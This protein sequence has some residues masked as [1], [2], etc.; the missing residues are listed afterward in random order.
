LNLAFSG[1]VGHGSFND[2]GVT[3]VVY[4]QFYILNVARI[5]SDC[6]G[7]SHIVLRFVHNLDA[8]VVQQIFVSAVA[9]QAK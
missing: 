5:E 7:K 6:L 4:G 8:D 9:V 3:V 2:E 1:V